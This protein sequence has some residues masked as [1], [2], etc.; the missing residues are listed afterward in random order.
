MGT[1]SSPTPTLDG[2][3]V[4]TRQLL[5]SSNL[6]K[7]PKFSA[8][9]WLSLHGLQGSLNFLQAYPWVFSHIPRVAYEV[10]LHLMVTLYHN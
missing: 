3:L 4:L 9:P 1:V 7:V 10:P 8:T 6:A 5:T 2:D